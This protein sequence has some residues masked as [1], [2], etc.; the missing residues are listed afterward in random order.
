MSTLKT[1]LL[2]AAI[3]AILLLGTALDGQP[4]DTE[5]ERAVAADV[6]AA[7]AKAKT[8]YPALLR[9]QQVFSRSKK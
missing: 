8:D 6:Q 1:T 5:A 3:A 9:A 2:A 4:S 7:I